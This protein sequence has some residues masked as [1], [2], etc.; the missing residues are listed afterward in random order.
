MPASGRA[1]LD[2]RV[3]YIPQQLGLVRSRS[4]LENTLIGA[5][6]RLG[7]VPSL[8]GWFPRELVELA[9]ERLRSLGIAHKAQER[10][11]SLSGGERQRVAIA[12][13]LMQE[14]QV[15]LADEFTSQ[16]DP[17]TAREILEIM[18]GISK[19]GVTLLI[20]T[21]QIELVG[22]YADR[23]VAIRAGEK[24]LDA[25]AAD[26]TPDHLTAVLRS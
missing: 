2:H 17:V 1:R 18:R 16:L 20:A 10:A 3:A 8:F 5:L 15:L 25:D 4:V 7:A 26:V 13:A 22:E 11:Y 14:P 24:V 23:V 12:R 6:W 21:H 19:E 9:H